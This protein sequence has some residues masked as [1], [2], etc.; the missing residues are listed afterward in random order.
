MDL[1]IIFGIALP[2]LVV[3]LFAY[4]LYLTRGVE[5]EHR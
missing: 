2:A 3:G 1:I 5:R 4:L